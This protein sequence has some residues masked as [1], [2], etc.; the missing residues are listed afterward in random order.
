MRPAIA[1]DVVHERRNMR[2]V[3]VV[4]DANFWIEPFAEGFDRLAG[5]ALGR[6]KVGGW[7]P[8]PVKPLFISQH[9]QDA[10]LCGAFIACKHDLH[11]GLVNSNY[12]AVGSDIVS[13]KFS[14]WLQAYANS[15]EACV[16]H[17]CLEFRAF[18]PHNAYCAINWTSVKDLPCD[19][20]NRKLVTELTFAK[21]SR[22]RLD[23]VLRSTP[24]AAFGFFV[25]HTL[26][27]FDV[28][29]VFKV[30]AAISYTKCT[31][32]ATFIWLWH[33]NKFLLP[34]ALILLLIIFLTCSWFSF[35]F[36][37]IARGSVGICRFLFVFPAR[38]IV[39]LRIA[40]HGFCAMGG[41]SARE[42]PDN[43]LEVSDVGGLVV[44][45]LDQLGQR[46]AR[47]HERV[48]KFIEVVA[49]A[50]SKATPKARNRSHCGLQRVGEN[51]SGVRLGGIVVGRALGLAVLVHATTRIASGRSLSSQNDKVNQVVALTGPKPSDSVSPI[52]FESASEGVGARRE[53]HQGPLRDLIFYIEITVCRAMIIGIELRYISWLITNK[54]ICSSCGS[55]TESIYFIYCSDS[56]WPEWRHFAP[57][58]SG[59]KNGHAATLR[60]PLSTSA[61]KFVRC[62]ESPGRDKGRGYRAARSRYRRRV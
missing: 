22:P 25:E 40:P 60:V 5:F 34:Q 56:F 50:L 29:D 33:N 10:A 6:E 49:C 31:T 13:D 42:L 21:Q 55:I 52:F 38:V 26:E 2:L 32:A 46:A 12:V 1:I 54:Q 37:T 57:E 53:P 15:L 9:D 51:L 20:F 3:A 14:Q 4:D 41:E 16:G 28:H 58:A 7:R 8:L 61:S 24:C 47:H 59:R 18:S 45:G 23:P 27:E 35:L 62:S 30:T 36:A 11:V 44:V 17:G 48:L 19:Y 43:S 39:C